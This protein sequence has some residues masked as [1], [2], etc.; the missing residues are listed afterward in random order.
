M[1]SH[2]QSSSTI[3]TSQTNVL[4]STLSKT[5]RILAEVEKIW[6]KSQLHDHETLSYESFQYYALNNSI[7]QVSLSNE[8]T[9]LII[10][11]IDKNRNMC[12]DKE[13]MVLFFEVMLQIENSGPDY[14]K[15]KSDIFTKII[16]FNNERA[17]D[18]LQQ[19]IQVESRKK[20]K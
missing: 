2:Q 5:I 10:S 9:E 11:N 7:S 6:I 19:G 20:L 12:I 1:L 14:E 3:Y 16:K 15:L 13:E 17:T 18:M 4:E 8:D